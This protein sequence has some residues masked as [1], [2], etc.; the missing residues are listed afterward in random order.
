[1]AQT[2]IEVPEVDAVLAAA[3]AVAAGVAAGAA[4]AAPAETRV[5]A[6]PVLAQTAQSVLVHQP[7][8]AL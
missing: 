8:T 7:P 5:A 4:G 6:G 3:A 1:V 2:A